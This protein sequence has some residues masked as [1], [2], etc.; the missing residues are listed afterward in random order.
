MTF[1]CLLPTY[2]YLILKKQLIFNEILF[3]N[4]LI[5]LLIGII[6]YLIN[7]WGAGD[8]KLFFVYCLLV[9][10]NK[11]CG[12]LSLPSVVILVN[13]FLAGMLL[14][15]FGSLKR[16]FEKK[17]GFFCKKK[18]AD[19]ARGLADIFLILASLG[20][21]VLSFFRKFTVLLNPFYGV[22]ILYGVYFL[23]MRILKTK[24]FK[25]LFLLVCLSI[26]LFR[27]YVDPM[28]KNFSDL[29]MYVR[30]MLLVSFIFALIKGVGDYVRDSEKRIAFAPIMFI[31]VMLSFTDFTFW[32]MN[33]LKF[34]RAGI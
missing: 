1:F 16:M 29:R 7:V 8:A 24:P 2:I 10:V 19:L 25:N 6:F 28:F 12:A 23:I 22:L 30:G 15:I 11:C 17:E 9:P 26:I 13:I 3:L 21:L 27:F 34:L 4:L 20:W 5:G 18:A 33:F 14:V 32:V 31:G